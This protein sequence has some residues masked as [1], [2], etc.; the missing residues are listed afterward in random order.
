MLKPILLVSVVIFVSG[1]TAATWNAQ[2]EIARLDAGLPEAR[3]DAQALRDEIALLRNEVT[4]TSA[5]VADLT[6]RLE[7]SEER[8][9]TA[10]MSDPEPHGEMNPDP[11]SRTGA[12]RSEP[13]PP[14]PADAPLQ[15]R[16]D[17]AVAEAFDRRDQTRREREERMRQAHIESLYLTQAMDL[18]LNQYQQDQMR[19]IQTDF[20]NQIRSFQQETQAQREAGTP[21]D[22]GAF[23]ARV[24]A[25]VEEMNSRAAQVLDASQYE[26]FLEMNNQTFG[27]DIPRWFGNGRRRSEGRSGR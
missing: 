22:E 15:A 18:E 13:A 6:A 9:A 12:E 19:Q 26:K 14:L 3:R 21:L 7:A 4:R 25:F 5:R 2:S 16:I 17:R 10:A 11:R 24:Q 1:L 20:R 27:P 8:L 23:R